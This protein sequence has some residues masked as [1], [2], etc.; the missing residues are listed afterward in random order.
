MMPSSATP[1]RVPISRATAARNRRASHDNRGDRL[2]F[3]TIPALAGTSEKRTSFSTEANP[4]SAPI[5]TNAA[6]DDW[7]RVDAGQ[8]RRFG[9]RSGCID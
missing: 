1:M 3:Q 7:L 9:I 8:P 2:Q 5:K 4:V 6:E